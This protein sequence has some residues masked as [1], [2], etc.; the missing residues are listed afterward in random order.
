MST[1]SISLSAA[2]VLAFATL[3]TATVRAAEPVA[4]YGAK[5]VGAMTLETLGRA[6]NGA[7]VQRQGGFASAGAAQWIR[8]PVVQVSAA[9]QT[10]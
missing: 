4:V 6:T 7:Q 8:I 2:A 9:A 10:F 5:T 3:G 1:Y